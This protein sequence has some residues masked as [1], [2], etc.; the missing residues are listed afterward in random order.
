MGF[1]GWAAAGLLTISRRS[2]LGVW[3]GLGELVGVER[4][5]RVD[6]GCQERG[7]RA[8]EGERD[9]VGVGCGGRLVVVASGEVEA[10]IGSRRVTAE[11]VWSRM[12]NRA[13]GGR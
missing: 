7:L 5:R 6:T 8:G 3:G 2:R 11:E 4:R 10:S 9:G 1:G 12:W 13:S